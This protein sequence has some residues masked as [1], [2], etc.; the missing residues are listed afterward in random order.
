MNC[1]ATILT[2]KKSLA[3]HDHGQINEFKAGCIACIPT[4][5]GY[6]SIGFSAGALARVSGM[7]VMEITLMSFL[8]YAGSGQFIVANM[9]QSQAAILSIW[10]AIFFVNLRHLLMSTYLVPFFKHLSKLKNGVLGAQVTD[11]TFGVAAVV[12]QEKGTL[13]FAWM[14]GLNMTAYLNW[15]LGNV[16]GAIAATYIPASF[17]NSLQFA[18]VAMFIGLIVMQIAPAKARAIQIFAAVMAVA[19]L[20]PISILFGREFSVVLT[21]IIASFIAMGVLRCKSDTKSS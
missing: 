15:I 19:L 1:C 16:M 6:L 5:L 8:L 21:A 17:I 11:E 20:E 2:P 12:A 3:M 13:S 7:S 4:V 10:I 9:V 18:L 14:F